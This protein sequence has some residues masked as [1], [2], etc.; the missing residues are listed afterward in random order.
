[1]VINTSVALTK[2]L[3]CDSTK[4]KDSRGYSICVR[5]NAG[6]VRLKRH[7]DPDK[8]KASRKSYFCRNKEE[9][10]KKRKEYNVKHRERKSAFFKEYYKNNLEKMRDKNRRFRNNAH[11]LYKIWE[12]MKRRCFN[13]N[14]RSY[15][16]YG[17]RGIT[18]CERWRT[19]FQNFLLDMESTWRS[20]LSIERMD[21]NGN[22][23]KENCKWATN[24]EQANNTRANISYRLSVADDS[25]IYHPYGNL[26]TLKEFSERTGMP[27]IVA[28]YRYA[29]NWDA[30]WILSSDYERRVYE[31]DGRFYSLAELSLMSDIPY[32]TIEGRI[33][34]MGWSVEKAVRTPKVWTPSDRQVPTYR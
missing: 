30:E 20:G 25:L 2:C 24:E 23:G 34:K 15:K 27:L 4:K 6:R 10:L 18:V 3:K 32:K 1:M 17:G 11:P 33:R 5:C 22:Y 26:T 9:I 12:A 8:F 7:A 16:D 31:Y 13:K 29:K 19:S 14:D 21:V 28:K